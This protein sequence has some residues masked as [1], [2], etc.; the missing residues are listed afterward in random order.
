M[1]KEDGITGRSSSW[2]KTPD[3]DSGREGA[4]PSLVRIQLAH[5]EKISERIYLDFFKDLVYLN[6]K[7]H[8]DRESESHIENFG[9]ISIHSSLMVKHTPVKRRESWFE[10]REWS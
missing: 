8:S 5:L 7:I 9:F 3:F 1:D 10:P 2:F 4:P 6:R